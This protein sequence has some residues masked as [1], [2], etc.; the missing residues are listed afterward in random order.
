MRRPQPARTPRVLSLALTTAVTGAAVVLGAPP[1]SAHTDLLGGTPGPGDVVGKRV[2]DLTLS[3]AD[4]LLGDGAQIKV[5]DA[6]GREVAGALSVSGAQA[7]LSLQGPARPGSYRVV[8]RVVAVDGHPITGSYGFRVAPGAAAVSGA[9]TVVG[10]GSSADSTAEVGGVIASL[11]AQ[12]A[13]GPSA[14]TWVIGS[15]GMATLVAL[16][17]VGARRRPQAVEVSAS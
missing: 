16:V 6:G 11:A 9:A 2:S 7:R 10:T 4:P 5:N 14:S 1:A 15:L 3:F 13:A 17:A 8:Y 12:P